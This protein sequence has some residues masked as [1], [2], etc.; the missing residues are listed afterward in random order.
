MQ[1]H[2]EIFL[3]LLCQTHIGIVCRTADAHTATTMLA[4]ILRGGRWQVCDQPSEGWLS[5]F[6]SVLCTA[7]PMSIAGVQQA[8]LLRSAPARAALRAH[9]I[10]LVGS[11]CA[12]AAAQTPLTVTIVSLQISF[13]K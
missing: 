7:P 4:S 5:S 8:C 9:G 10:L 3:N 6:A 1:H 12:T 13:Q 11:G 2:E